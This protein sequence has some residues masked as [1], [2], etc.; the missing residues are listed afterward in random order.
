VASREPTGPAF[1]ASAGLETAVTCSAFAGHPPTVS[2]VTEVD[3]VTE[4]VSVDDPGVGGFAFITV[5]VGCDLG[6][7]GAESVGVEL[8]HD[9]LRLGYAPVADGEVGLAFA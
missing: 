8:G 9:L 6:G 3:E 7:D 2:V 5:D 1:A 4:A